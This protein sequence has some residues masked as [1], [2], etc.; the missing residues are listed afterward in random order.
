MADVDRNKLLSLMENYKKNIEKE[1]GAKV[2]R[3]SNRISS[4]E[5]TE[6][7]QE[8]MPHHLGFYERM[9]N[10]S[11]KWLKFGVDKKKEAELQESINIT[12][13]NITPMGAVSFSYTAPIFIF[14]LG[15][16]PFFLI[17]QSMFFVLFFMILAACLIKPFAKVPMF[18][19][20]KWRMKASN[21]MVLCIFYVV[22]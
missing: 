14:L 18:I 3:K 1:L 8:Y 21:E 16:F 22:T 4:L 2:E 9:C 17:F 19:A 5:Y 11:E 12:H 15:A 20:N 13:L 10:L 6:F 7:K